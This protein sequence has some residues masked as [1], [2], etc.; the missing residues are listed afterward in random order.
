MVEMTPARARRERDKLQQRQAILDAAREIA[1]SE[2]WGAV[3]TRRVAERIE[4]THPTIY[5]HFESKGALLAE[6]TREGYRL[7][8]AEL[9]AARARARD[10]EQVVRDMAQAYCAFAWTHRELYEAMHG[11]SGVSIEPEAYRKEG[12]AVIAEARAALEAWA[13]A[14]GVKTARV[15]DAVLILWS[16]LHGIASLALNKQIVGGKKHAAALAARVVDDLLSAWRV[17]KHV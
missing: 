1:A 17:A 15:D 3:T 13:K 2:G 5:E 8:L 9:Q 14:E 12:E 16:T 4:Y 6:L 10:P 7:L 11:L